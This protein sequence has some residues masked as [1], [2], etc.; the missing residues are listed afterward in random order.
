[1]IHIPP[2]K[3]VCFNYLCF[4][5]FCSNTLF[6]QQ[7]DSLFVEYLFEKKYY[8]D[9]IR[10]TDQKGQA[11]SYYRGLAFYNQQQIDSAIYNFDK[12]PVG[13]PSF[14]KS[15]FLVGFGQAFL[16]K[17]GI[18]YQTFAQSKVED[19]LQS[20][21]KNFELAGLALLQRDT[22]AFASYQKNFRGNFFAFS[23]EEEKLKEIGVLIRKHKKKSPLLAGA[24]SVV[25]PG[26]GKIYAG[27]TGQGIITFIQNLALGLQA[28][29]AYRRDGWKSPRFII[30]GGL[31]TFFYVGNIWGSTLS[32]HIRQ[33]EFNDKMNGQILLNMQTPLRVVFGQ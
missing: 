22:S 10:W 7:S 2:F 18:S 20:A 25:V 9:I 30:Y 27:K 15:R 12:L 17:Y 16:K 19:T 28:Y 29:E 11:F 24:M 1:M 6:G 4:F 13:H 26:S 5:I 31:F 23:Q 33:Q 21:L 8:A 14:I 32:V 3:W